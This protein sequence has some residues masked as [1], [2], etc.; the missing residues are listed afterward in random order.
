[1]ASELLIKSWEIRNLKKI[2][3]Q[4]LIQ[5]EGIWHIKT[6][7]ILALIELSKRIQE[8]VSLPDILNCSSPSNIIAYFNHI[9]LNISFALILPLLRMVY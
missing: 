5:I 3:Y 9:F 4:K 1:M 7:E 6:I 8:Q 2:T